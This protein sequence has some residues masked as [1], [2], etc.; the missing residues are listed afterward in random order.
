VGGLALLASAPAVLAA[1]G[2]ANRWAVSIATAGAAVLI[3]A[4]AVWQ[5]RYK[6]AAQRSD[7]RALSLEAG[8]LVLS[9]GR[10]PKVCQV[11][12]PILLGVHPSSPVRIQ[13][14]SQRGDLLPERVPEYV[15][16][17]IDVELR[18]RLGMSGFVL[19]VGDST[20]GK[21]RAAYEAIVSL[22]NHLLIAPHGGDAL[23]AAVS[24]AAS[25][26]RCVLW[27]DDLEKY[28]GTGGLTRANIGRL[29]GDKQSHR[30]VVATMRA[31]EETRIM[32]EVAADE[33]AWQSHKEA[34]DVLEQAHR[35]PLPR[36]FSPAELER[37]RAFRGDSRIVDALGQASIYGI[38]EYLAAGPELL[39]D[40]ENAWSP[41]T[42]P[43]APSHPRGAALIAAAIDIRRSGY[44]SPLPRNLLEQVHGHYLS[45]HG[46]SRLCPESLADAWTWTTRPQRATTALLHCIDDRHVQVFD[47]LLDAVQRRAGPGGHAPD[48][49]LEA[50]L[51]ECAPVDAVNIGGT[52]YFH[53]QYDLAEA[54]WLT[55]YRSQARDLGPEHLNTL[56]SCGSRANMLRDLGRYEECESE[57]QAIIEIGTRA[58]GP[59]HPRV[60]LSRNGRAFAL[61]RLGRFEEAE[62][63][64]RTVRDIACRILGPEHYVTTNSRHLRAIALH[65]LGRLSEAE[66]EN[67]AVLGIWTRV[68]GPEHMSTLLSHGNLA[69]LL[70]ETGRLDEAKREARTV[71]A[72]Q[73][74]VLG[75]EH[76]QT[77]RTSH[78]LSRMENEGDLS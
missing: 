72:I 28:L 62:Q 16:R 52:A 47:Y 56:E 44:A 11:A 32:S 7:E 78:E 4:A 36:I 69:L 5:E 26:R 55:A 35:I 48:S 51:G 46:G 29:L 49:V 61:I 22:Q 38:A 41:N 77:K 3:A 25:T 13:S 19:L 76:P 75:P 54:A 59:E 70:Y 45:Q 18:Q 1:F 40:W 65:H 21:S 53:G 68:Y 58:Y 10:L 24:K 9:N 64:L 66:E 8:C 6:R 73:T 43:R 14:H 67:R 37:A 17:D 50:A 60:L 15:P 27:L 23:A 20:A 42:D 39:R 57:H 63:E 71:L 12:D 74:R 2:L 33:H 34:L 30:V 31:A